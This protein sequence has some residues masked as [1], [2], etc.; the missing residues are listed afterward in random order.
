MRDEIHEILQLGPLPETVAVD[1][2]T[3]E[4]LDSF[5]LLLKQLPTPVTDD[6]ARALSSLFGP[7]DCHG[8]AWTLLHIVE[9][10]PN[11]PLE[12]VYEASSKWRLRL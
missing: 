12:D 3:E 2:S 6:E 9:T 7:D 4:L 10:A 8:L 1:E 11:W 5:Y